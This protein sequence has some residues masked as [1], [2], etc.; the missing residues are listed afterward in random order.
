MPD[1]GKNELE[2]RRNRAWHIPEL[3]GKFVVRLEGAL[4]LDSHRGYTYSL[5]PVWKPA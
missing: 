2:P 1:L 4:N 3:S 5:K